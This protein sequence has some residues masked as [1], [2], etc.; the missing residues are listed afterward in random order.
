MPDRDQYSA[1][2]EKI[3]G[4]RTLHGSESLCKLLRYLA[5][6][7]IDQ[8]GVHLKEYQIATEVFGRPADF[9]P[10]LDSTIR[11]QAG[12]LR[13]KLAEYYGSEGTEDP[14][15]IE[16]PK[17][18]YVV[19]FH[20]RAATGSKPNGNGTAQHT[21]AE[22]SVKETHRK[23]SVGVIALAIALAVALVTIA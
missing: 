2:L 21:V 12:R 8:P 23:P 15:M 7:A 10:Q 6:H 16:L 11:V 5:L 3:L 22:N 14:V 20:Q 18:A 13:A 1:Q 17:G 19:S 4:S 9:D